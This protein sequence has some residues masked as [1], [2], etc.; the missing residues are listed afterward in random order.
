MEFSGNSGN[1]G[2]KKY[3]PYGGLMAE[4]TEHLWEGLQ[5]QEAVVK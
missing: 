5:L 1:S 2:N 4:S 3:Y